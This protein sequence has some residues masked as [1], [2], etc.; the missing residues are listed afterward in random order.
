[1]SEEATR[2]VAED[3][4]AGT[5]RRTVDV[6]VPLFNE[7][8]GIEAFHRALASVLDALGA[9]YDCSVI[10]VVDPSPD[11]TAEKIRELADADPRVRG[12]VLLRRAGHQMSL[13]AGLK[14]S[15][16]DAVIMMDGDLQHPPEL[17]PE[18]LA[19]HEEGFDVVQTVRTSTEGQGRVARALSQGFY[20]LMGRLSEVKMVPGGA[21]Y[22]LLSQR[23]AHIL[24]E[25]IV[26][27]DRF[28]RGLIPWLGVRTATIDFVAPPREAGQ[29]KYSFRRSLAFA[30][31]GIVSFSKVPLQVGI[32][33]GLFV[34]LIGVIAGI[35]ALISWLAGADI[36]AG[37]TTL[38]V[39]VAL[40]SGMQLVTLGLVG[41]YVGVVF[42]EAKR[43]PQILIADRLGESGTKA[44]S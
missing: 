4:D 26:E 17:I 41:L 16:A 31:T 29:S 18:L 10:Y 3:V 36:P 6:V 5:P 42:D 30:V 27:S 24:S 25:D 9:R 1:M 43:R 35:A 20:R 12:L 44:E 23:V 7:A 21:D 32:V 2:T 39:L 37:W 15:T 13:V 11:G 40:L 14:E 34:S 19:L 8:E 22:R 33:L 38:V 28:L